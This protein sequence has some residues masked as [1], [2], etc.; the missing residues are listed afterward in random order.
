VI[1]EKTEFDPFSPR[2]VEPTVAAATPPAPPAP[3]VT[4]KVVAVNVKPDTQA[5]NGLTV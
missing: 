5:P 2:S 4:G 3:T 1:V